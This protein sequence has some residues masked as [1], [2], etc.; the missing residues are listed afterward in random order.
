MT[1][2]ENELKNDGSDLHDKRVK[3]GEM[4]RQTREQT[5]MTVESLAQS[6]KITAHFIAALESGAFEKLPGAVFGRGF[7]KNLCKALNIDA[8]AVMEQY[9]SCWPQGEQKVDLVVKGPDKPARRVAGATRTQSV[10]HSNNA[11]KPSNPAT[12]WLAMGLPALA[13][14]LIAAA[15]RFFGSVDET[16]VSS[17]VAIQMPPDAETALSTDRS[18][19]ELADTEH[20]E[21]TT[22]TPETADA[23]AVQ[24][25]QTSSNAPE[26]VADKK[27]AFDQTIE[28]IAKKDVKIRLSIDG[29]RRDAE[30]IRAGTYRYTFEQRAEL[31]VYDASAVEISFNGKPLGELGG[32]GRIR[33]LSFAAPG[34]GAAVNDIGNPDKKL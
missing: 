33:R 11:Q 24:R 4:L 32:P 22:E 28:V 19:E 18:S 9:N 6:T 15:I 8:T 34:I 10:Q 27:P 29:K 13:F 14:V 2:N 20:E 5:G 1:T 16:S 30:D 23:P 3:F 26:V 12:A 21:T 31:M 17:H 7:V 25:E